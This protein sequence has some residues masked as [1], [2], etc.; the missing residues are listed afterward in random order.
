MK[1]RTIGG[2]EV[3]CMG[4]PSSM[5]AELFPLGVNVFLWDGKFERPG[6]SLLVCRAGDLNEIPEGVDVVLWT[7]DPADIGALDKFKTFGMAGKLSRFPLV[8]ALHEAGVAAQKRGVRAD[9]HRMRALEVTV[10]TANADAALAPSQS[11]KFGDHSPLQCAQ[12]VGW[13][14]FA[15]PDWDAY[16][17]PAWSEVL[18]AN[19]AELQFLFARSVPG[20][21]VVWV[22]A[23]HALAAVEWAKRPFADAEVNLLLGPGGPHG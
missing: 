7:G 8:R 6:P 15:I 17:D 14:G 16:A 11:W 20:V 18:E 21:H 2:L 19:G 10:S 23:A 13:A 4:A 12:D 5:A 3:S 22:D 1:T 9:G